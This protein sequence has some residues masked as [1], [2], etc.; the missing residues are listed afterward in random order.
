MLQNIGLEIIQYIINTCVFLQSIFWRNNAMILW[1]K[2]D[3]TL[4]YAEVVDVYI[5]N[6]V[7]LTTIIFSFNFSLTLSR[8]NN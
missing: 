6:K 5:K 4:M 8:I 7:E 1:T 3:E 2:Y